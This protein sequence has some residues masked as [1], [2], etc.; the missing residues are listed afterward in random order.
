MTSPVPNPLYRPY[1]QHTPFTPFGWLKQPKD[2]RDFIYDP[3]KAGI[4]VL[5]DYVD[6]TSMFPACYN[7]GRLGSCTANAIAGAFE[8]ERTRQK[9]VPDFVPSRLFIY[10]FER[11]REGT[12]ALD[13]GA[14][15]R[16]GFK[17]I[18]NEGVCGE[19]LWAYF[20]DV[21]HFIIKPDARALFSAAHHRAIRY[22]A[23]AQDLQHI[24]TVLASGRCVVFGF[25]VYAS[26]MS[27]IVALT[28]QVPMP[29]PGENVLGGHAVVIVGYNNQTQTFRCRNSWGSNWGI[30]G[31]FDIPFMYLANWQ[32]ASDFWTI[33]Y[34]NQVPS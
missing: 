11:K 1:V 5:P 25:V 10:F 34:I 6:W 28:G 20:D 13:S 9:L 3:S 8:F 19:Q 32:L 14:Y 27:Q 18:N 4:S 33:N 24:K 16:D 12:V 31:Y 29:L 17:S 22:E 26:F 21:T 15:I 30:N 7:Q 2:D 23:V